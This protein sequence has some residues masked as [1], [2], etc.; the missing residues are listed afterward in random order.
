MADWAAMSEEKGTSMKKWIKDNVNVRW[1]FSPEQ[2]SLI[3]ELGPILCE[4][5]SD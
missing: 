4:E 5:D 3:N 1:K 2:V